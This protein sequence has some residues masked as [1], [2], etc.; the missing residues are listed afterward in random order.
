[1]ARG[2]A[3]RLL[4]MVEEMLAAEGLGWQ[5]L[6]ALAVCTGPGNFTGVRIAVAAARGLALAL[7]VPAIGITRFEALAHRW[8]G[9]LLVTLDGHRGQVFA[10]DFL[11]GRP[12]GPAA[13]ETLEAM[14]PRPQGTLC[15]GFAADALA[16][17]WGLTPGPEAQVADPAALA[18]V[19][20]TRL[21]EFQPRPAPV[22]LRPPDAVPPTDALP[23]L[24]DDA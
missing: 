4:A 11:H 12:C 10:Q 6:D 7:G 2:Q 5:D 13:T 19:A 9:R 21:G 20:A 24:L 1:M 18:Q 22:Y 14:A 3:E 8:P 23:A 17:R 16:A 15:L